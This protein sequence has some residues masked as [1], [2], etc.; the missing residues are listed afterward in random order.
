MDYVMINEQ[1]KGLNNVPKAESRSLLPCSNDI[2]CGSALGYG[3]IECSEKMEKAFNVLFEEFIKSNNDMKN[4]TNQ[5]DS[6]L[7]ESINIESGR[8]K[9]NTNATADT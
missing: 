9:N 2:M 4:A 8:A 3:H 1:G 6:D 5:V 7:F